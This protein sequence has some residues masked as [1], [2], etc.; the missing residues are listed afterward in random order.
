MDKLAI[1]RITSK[2]ITIGVFM[3]SVILSGC[4]RGTVVYR[5]QIPI[6]DNSTFYDAQGNFDEGAAKDAYISLMKY[7]GYPIFPETRK[8]L[9]VSDYGTG[10]FT[11]LGLGAHMFI[12]QEKDHYM[13]MDLF[14][15]PHQMLP[16]HWHLPAE[17]NP[18]KREG[19]LVRSGK[20]YIGGIGDDN[21][22]AHPEVVIPNCHMQGT[23]MT[24]HVVPAT[25]GEFV[26]LAEIESRHWQF[27]GPEGA[28]IT[29]VATI[30]TNSGVR[31]SDI[32]INDHFLG[33]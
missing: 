7:H 32:G 11:K 23:T 20:S 5:S 27:G 33:N 22:T 6:F 31:H 10:Q 29:E 24:K 9:W 2:L 12:N 25:E 4:T 16:E 8:N 30:H 15:L 26:G 21:L 14:L 19:W 1:T 28:I 3:A 17:N 13:L 18:A